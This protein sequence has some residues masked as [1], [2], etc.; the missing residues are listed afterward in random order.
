M[1]SQSRINHLLQEKDHVFYGQVKDGQTTPPN[2]VIRLKN[3]NQLAFGYHYLAKEMQYN[4]SKGITL[5]FLDPD[6]TKTIHIE[7]RN[8]LPLWNA[9]VWHKVSFITELEYQS[10]SDNDTALYIHSITIT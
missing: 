2:L 9:L 1:E 3:G 7:G 8:L 10:I 5:Y 6:G 4:P